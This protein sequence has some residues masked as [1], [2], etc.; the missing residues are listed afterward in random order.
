ME[1]NRAKLNEPKQR[2]VFEIFR[3]GVLR[4]LNA[5]EVRE[6]LKEI[7]TF[8]GVLTLSSLAGAAVW[9]FLG[10]SL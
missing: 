3:A 5:S 4:W 1:M 7:A 2:S 8:S 6:M 9:V 10:G